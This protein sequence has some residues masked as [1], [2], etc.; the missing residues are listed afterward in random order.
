MRKPAQPRNLIAELSVTDDGEGGRFSGIAYSGGRIPSWNAVIDLATTRIADSMP[1]L[2]SHDK[3]AT[4]GLIEKATNDKRQISV[5]GELFG[6]IDDQADAIRKKAKRGIKYQMSVGLYE[7]NDEFVAA[8]KTIKLNGQTFTG[9]LLVLRDGLIREAS[10]VTLGADPNTSAQFFGADSPNFEEHAMTPEEMQARIAALEGDNAT[11][12]QRAEA[13]EAA[14]AKTKREAREKSVKEL[15]AAT[16][17]EFTE[18]AAKA[19]MDMADEAF[20]AVAADLKAAH[21][22]GKNNAERPELR[23][24]FNEHTPGRNAG[25]VSP[26]LADAQA[27]G[28]A[29]PN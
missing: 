18:A 9:P 1:L 22:K 4:I 19:Y 11:L 3:A 27:R 20:E 5:E 24:L 14:V 10:I 6:D 7:S 17:R 25:A 16:G 8:G 28:W 12:T 2:D 15:F 29:K 13:A 23:H 21:G 26:L